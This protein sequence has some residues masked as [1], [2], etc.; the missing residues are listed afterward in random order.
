M[1]LLLV[2]TRQLKFL[3]DKTDER[4]RGRERGKERERELS[5]SV[6]M[7]NIEEEKRGKEDGEQ[8]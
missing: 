7:I 2:R 5:G 6:K 8:Y 3:S 1:G 4:E